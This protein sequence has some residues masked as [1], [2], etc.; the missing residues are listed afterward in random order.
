MS[1]NGSFLKG[2]E[3]VGSFLVRDY[4][5]VSYIALRSRHPIL[6]QIALD[7]IGL[8]SSHISY[9]GHLRIDWDLLGTNLTQ[10]KAADRAADCFLFATSRGWLFLTSL[11]TRMALTGKLGESWLCDLTR[12]AC[13][14]IDFVRV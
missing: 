5:L 9:L 2:M 10:R 3:F 12:E 8:D 6:L 1:S 7:R 4:R 14:S 13:R 11:Y